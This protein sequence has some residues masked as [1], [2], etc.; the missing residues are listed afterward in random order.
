MF[1]RMAERQREQSRRM[2]ALTAT[3]MS[4]AEAYMRVSCEMEWEERDAIE[5]AKLADIRE[6]G[7]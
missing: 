5:Q 6:N 7:T 1:Q 4:S 3:G 2:D